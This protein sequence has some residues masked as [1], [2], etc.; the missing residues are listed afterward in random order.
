[1][2]ARLI[3]EF[4]G[5]FTLI[6]VGLGVALT[7]GNDIVAVAF[8]HGLAIAIMVTAI[9]HVSG[10]HLNPAVTI[11]M[12]LMRKIEAP[13]AAA[14]VGIQLLGATLAALFVKVAFPT[15]DTIKD[16]VGAPQ[17]IDGVS[18][19]QG[20]A[21]EA[22]ATFFL[23]WVIFAVAV[24][25]DGAFFKVAGLPIG[26][27]V[28]MGLLA[29]GTVT[30]GAMNPARAFGPELAG[31]FWTDWAVYWIGPIIGAVLAAA[32]YMYVVRPRLADASS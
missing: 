12:L 23:V 22:M 1:M 7:S 20:I 24:D 19:S 29:I 15:G 26:F 13:A 25:R 28:T 6:A 30:G 4:V 17:L 11:S 21:L 32:A 5:T 8:A 18:M 9:G 14:Y 31:G 27:A 3:S 16:G 2:P 10:G